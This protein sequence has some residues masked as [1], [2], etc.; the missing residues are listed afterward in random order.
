MSGEEA[1]YTLGESF[2]EGKRSFGGQ[3]G[4]SPVVAARMEREGGEE[5]KK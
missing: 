4:G 2:T 5:R 3:T 1:E